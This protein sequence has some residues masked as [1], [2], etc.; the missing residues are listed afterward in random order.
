MRNWKFVNRAPPLIFDR[1]PAVF[2]SLI[3]CIDIAIRLSFG[4]SLLKIGDVPKFG[5]N[6]DNTLSEAL[7]KLE[8]KE[9]MNLSKPPA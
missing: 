9:E 5:C 7:S 8:G 4:I 1:Y 2:E 6:S 3:N